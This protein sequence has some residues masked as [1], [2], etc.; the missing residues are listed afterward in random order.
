MNVQTAAADDVV[1]KG[2]FARRCN[3]TPG[4][5]SQWIS[6]KKISGDAIV[7]EGREARIRES[8]AKAQLRLRRD[9]GQ[10]LGNGLGT[11]LTPAGPAPQAALQPSPPAAPSEPGDPIEEQIK[12]QRLEQYQRQNRKAAEDEALRAGLLTAADD[13]S[14]QMARIASQLLTVFEGALPEFAQSVAAQFQVPQRDV[15]HLLRQE[16]NKVRAS[17]AARMTGMAEEMPKFKTFDISD[18][19]QDP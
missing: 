10:G 17:A 6:E 11:R 16:M 3:V 1:T 19:A 5:V 2:E 9:V 15:L 18:T 14:A 4:R 7:G 12:R 8:V 13:A